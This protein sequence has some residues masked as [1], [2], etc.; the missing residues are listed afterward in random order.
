M[1]KVT[2]NKSAS[3]SLDQLN[4]TLNRRIIA[5]IEAL[6]INPRP[7][8]CIKLSGSY[9]RWRIRVGNYRIIYSVDDII[10]IVAVE[11]I[12]HRKEVYE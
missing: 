3:K 1:Y 10:R 2:F 8:G 4:K 5:K 6:A 11:R 12:A 7:A 9:N